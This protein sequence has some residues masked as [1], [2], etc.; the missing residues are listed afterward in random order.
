MEG[1][2]WGPCL[3]SLAFLNGAHSGIADRGWAWVWKCWGG[4]ELIQRFSHWVPTSLFYT[5]KSPFPPESNTTAL[6]IWERR[7]GAQDV[8]RLCLPPAKNNTAAG[9]GL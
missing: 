2:G 3:A 7:L 1:Y 8:S 4:E 6:P 5:L 9:H